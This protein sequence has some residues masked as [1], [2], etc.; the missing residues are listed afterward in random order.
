VLDYTAGSPPAL[1]VSV[2]APNVDVTLGVAIVA[3]VPKLQ[4]KDNT[5]AVIQSYTFDWTDGEQHLYAI[6]I[7][8]GVVSLA[9]DGTVLAPTVATGSFPGAALDDQ[10]EFGFDHTGYAAD[11]TLLWR[12]VSYSVLP[13][14][15]LA[16]TLGVWKGG[17]KADINNWEI[18]RT[19]STSARNSDQ[20]G[21]VI[22]TMDWQSPMD[23]QVY[24]NDQWG[25]TIL[26]PDL[27]N[28]PFY[29][30]GEY[31]TQI[32]NPSQGWINVEYPQLPR[33]SAAFGSVSFGALE[34]SGVT[35][36]LWESIGYT[37]AKTPTDDHQSAP[38]MVLNQFNIITS[39]ER[40]QDYTLET[41]TLTPES[42]RRVS[43]VPA[44]QYAQEVYKILDGSTIYT[45]NQWQFDPET[46]IVTLNSGYSFVSSTVTVMFIPGVPVTTTYLINQPLFDSAVLLNDLTPP[47]PKSRMA[48]A[49]A[50]LTT[51]T[52]GD[53]LLFTDAADTLYEGMEFME[54]TDG[55]WERLIAVPGE[56]W[57]SDNSDDQ[58]AE[59][60]AVYSLTGLGPSLGGVGESAGL[61]ETGTYV[62]DSQSNYV[63]G[64]SGPM[65]T[66]ASPFPQ[67][68]GVEIVLDGVFVLATGNFYR[69]PVT[70]RYNRVLIANS[71]SGGR[72]GP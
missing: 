5:G 58:A 51:G 39:G 33:V 19:D 12:A 17:D 26:R 45:R 7:S 40:K 11:A 48:A 43:L 41:V 66:E 70:G 57:L 47:F 28:P 24:L 6:T 2:R 42:A 13:P 69:G 22:Q 27:A 72:I 1:F 55:G 56:G 32:V 18:P 16:R 60:D 15:G 37:L 63:I 68:E 8:G 20:T 61:N 30:A 4:L 38:R 9:A 31:P 50:S 36:H 10:I 3:L 59:G 46:Q 14:A 64:F 71:F 23:V 35:Q 65:Y 29:V 62:G 25:V 53:V 67:E 54:V 34:A 21:P 49:T 52:T 44:H